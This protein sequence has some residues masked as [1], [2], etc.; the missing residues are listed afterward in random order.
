MTLIQR[1][2]L[3]VVAVVAAVA[4][5]AG[6]S[7]PAVAAMELIH[8]AWPPAVVYMNRVTLPKV[9]KE[10][11][12]ET[13]GEIKWKLVPGG[14]L[15]GPKES[16]QATSEGLIQGALGIST[17]V[18]NLVPSLN[19]IY[20]TIVF[21]SDVI[22][23]TGAAVETLT[24]E[25][26]SCLAEF[27]KI[28]IVPL[29]G[30]TSSNYYLDCRTPV[31]TVADL[32]GKRVRGTGG[33][34]VLWNTAGAVAVTATLPEALTLLQ[35]GG[36]DCQHGVHSWLKT[37]GYAD[38]AKYITDY[39]TG[40]SGPAIGLMLNRD[41]WNKMTAE[42]KII[43]LKKAAWIS[44]AEA[45]GEFTI[46]NQNHLKDVMKNRGVKLVKADGPSFDTL[47][48]K[49]RSIQ[50]LNVVSS[51]K[52]FGVPDPKKIMDTYLANVK[53]WEGLTKGIGT[54]IDKFADLIW[55]E[56]YSKVDVNTF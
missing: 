5:S 22:P 29:S 9:F 46:D 7:K 17:Y 13:H 19:T 31:H 24:L 20:Q 15:A 36:L 33:N 25:C 10:I 45:I 1:S 34:A 47:F 55:R 35:R 14:Q 28:N 42:Q 43:H 53:K 39:P 40:L 11:E 56:V 6:A 3:A 44:A 38:F 32:K 27:K 4:F 12:Q 49:Y 37:F 23:A 30:W 16:F 50:E 26:P 21:G 18:P 2:W 41:A 51:G 52:K 54:D 48:D 8:G